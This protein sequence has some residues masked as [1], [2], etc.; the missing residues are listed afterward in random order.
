MNR[1]PLHGYPHCW[2]CGEHL[3]T[4]GVLAWHE[5][6]YHDVGLLRAA[7]TTWPTCCCH[8]DERRH[9]ENGCADCTCT[10]FQPCRG[11][12]PIPAWMRE[13]SRAVS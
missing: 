7:L 4:R 3:Q 11:K 10:H 13:L 8:H 12:R 9:R 6:G 2:T 1:E 5:L